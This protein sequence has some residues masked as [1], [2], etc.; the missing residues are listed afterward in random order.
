VGAEVGR[1]TGV[2]EAAGLVGAGE[3]DGTAVAGISAAL[4]PQATSRALNRITAASAA[5]G[6]RCRFGIMASF[7]SSYCIEELD[8]VMS[9]LVAI[10][11]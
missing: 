4:V 6:L 3:A 7:L 9:R 1:G 5:V 2:G 11:P 10:N 8:F